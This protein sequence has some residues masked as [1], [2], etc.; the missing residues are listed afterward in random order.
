MAFS[1]INI[2]KVTNNLFQGPKKGNGKQM[3]EISGGKNNS[4]LENNQTTIKSSS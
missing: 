1:D 4:K 2:I 3:K